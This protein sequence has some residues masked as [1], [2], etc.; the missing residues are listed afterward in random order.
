MNKIS[1]IPN[2]KNGSKN[3]EKL[4]SIEFLDQHIP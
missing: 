2:L 3:I 4:S 1:G